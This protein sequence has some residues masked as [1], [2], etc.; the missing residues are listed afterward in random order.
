MLELKSTYKLR[1]A[2]FDANN[3]VE[4]LMKRD[5]ELIIRDTAQKPTRKNFIELGQSEVPTCLGSFGS[6]G[7][8]SF[9]VRCVKD[10]YISTDQMTFT[11]KVDNSRCS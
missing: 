1:V 10:S 8:S 4:K 11:G 2:V 5:S 7:I 3:R 6:G 9:M